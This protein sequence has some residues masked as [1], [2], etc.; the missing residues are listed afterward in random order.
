M[1]AGSGAA[2]GRPAGGHR[3]A[4]GGPAARR[5]AEVGEQDVALRG[6]QLPAGPQEL[7]EQRV[8]VAR[9]P[10]SVG[11]WVTV[12]STTRRAGPAHR[13]GRSPSRSRTRCPSTV[14]PGRCRRGGGRRR[15][16][17]GRA[18]SQPVR[19]GTPAHGQLG[20]GVAGSPR[21]PLRPGAAVAGDGHGAAGRRGCPPTSPVSTRPGPG[22]DEDP[23]AGGVHG[24]DLLDEADRRADLARRARARTASG[25]AGYGRGGAV[26]PHRELRRAA[27]ACSASAVGEALARAG[28]Q[29]AVEGAG[30]REPLG[31]EPGVPQRVDGRVDRRRSGPEIDV[32]RGRVVVGHD[33]PSAS[34]PSPQHA[35]RPA[36][37]RAGDGGHRAGVVARRR[38]RIA[39]ARSALSS[40]QRRGSKAPAAHSATSSP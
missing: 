40:Q 9:A 38:A 28:D 35:A 13:A 24:L 26:G 12:A 21:R 18:N 32:C 31:A 3:W 2:A 36:S 8:P 23:G 16:R 37:A 25:S 15:R 1:A 7:G 5:R 6:D 14:Q 39:S 10:P 27:P 30:H 34:R 29:R 17:P 22:L 11:R 20:E 33:H 19:T 4:A